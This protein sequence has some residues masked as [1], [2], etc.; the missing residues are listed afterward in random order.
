MAL[1]ETAA[2]WVVKHGISLVGIDALSIAPY[3]FS[4]QT[5]ATLL[6][7][8]VV[9]VEGLDLH[10]VRAGVYELMVAPLKIRN[11]DGAPAR[12]ILKDNDQLP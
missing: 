4:Y 6:N 8:D 7:A 1:D 11:C 9:I 3:G 12:V 10:G 5:H 2:D